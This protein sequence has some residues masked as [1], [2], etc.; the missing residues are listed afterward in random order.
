MLLAFIRV[1]YFTG[2]IEVAFSLDMG[3]VECRGHPKVIIY[4]LSEDEEV[5]FHETMRVV[6]VGNLHH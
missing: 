5:V 3:I 6:S 4:L 2:H 1:N